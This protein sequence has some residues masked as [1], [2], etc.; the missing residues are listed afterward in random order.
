M[1]IVNP[2]QHASDLQLI[3]AS[4]QTLWSGG[5]KQHRSTGR[6]ALIILADNPPCLGQSHPI[7]WLSEC[8]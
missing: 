7:R 5:P 3:R 2:D 4:S 1:N 8:R 6:G